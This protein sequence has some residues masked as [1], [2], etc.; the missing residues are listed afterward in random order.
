MLA[1]SLDPTI[2]A[3]CSG[4]PSSRSVRRTSFR[5]MNLIH[6]V[7]PDKSKISRSSLRRPN[8]SLINSISFGRSPAIDR[9]TNPSLILARACWFKNMNPVH[10]KDR[11]PPPLEISPQSDPTFATMGVASSSRHNRICSRNLMRSHAFLLLERWISQ[12]YHPN[13]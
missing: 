7:L 6:V 12:I 10:E 9:R 1:L 13:M 2:Y 11:R 8:N 5:M 3:V 4:L